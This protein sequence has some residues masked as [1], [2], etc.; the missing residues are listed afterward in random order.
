MTQPPVFAS[1]KTAAAKEAEL[2]RLKRER[3]EAQVRAQRELQVREARRSAGAFVEYALRNEQDDTKLSNAA[4]HWDWQEFLEENRY[5]VLIAPVEHAK[6]QQVAIGK[7]IWLLG[8]HPEWRGAI[9]SNTEEQAK[10]VLRQIRTEIERNPR[11]QEVFPDLKPSTRDE[12]PWHSTAITVERKTR[13]KDPSLQV[14]GLFGPIVGSRLDFVILDDVLD[15]E[16]TRTE[17][18]RKKTIE[19]VDTSVITRLVERAL[20][21]AIGTPW[22]PDDLLHELSKRPLFAT[23]RY[24]A[25]LNP[26]DPPKR[27]IP[28][29]PEQ[30]PLPRLLARQ[31]ITP[32]LVFARKYL[33][34]VRLDTTSRF[35][36]VWLDR[37]CQL[38]KGRTFMAEAPRNHVRGPK[39]PCFT[40]VDL[41]VG[42][43]SSNALTVMFTLALQPNGRRLVVDIEAGRWQ[44]PEIIDRLASIW[45]RYGSEILVENNGAQQ[46]L[47]D[48]CQGRVPVRGFHTTAGA[49]NAED[50][51][52]ESM[53]VEMRNGEWALPSGSDGLMVHE[54]GKAWCNELLFYD[55]DVHTGDRVIASWL[56][57][58]AL[59][60]F[61][62]PRVRQLDAQRR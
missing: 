62:Q 9:I 54:E 29:W 14:M 58:E 21:Y 60:K 46:F 40:G 41:G 44:A 35:R 50:F 10:K 8:K 49:K 55:P 13:S 26:D 53:A 30:W 36:Q 17:E 31:Q 48:M 45:R 25:V 16:N 33:C 24:S 28:L 4:F 5:A 37:M 23:K 52:I 6:S 42:R 61:S 59:R 12:D 18:Q 56:A 11:I 19:W 34:R 32:E 20:F 51:G 7:V 39:L 15:F 3:L 38:G 22:H 57:R 2:A 27:W 47:I 1:S 43:N